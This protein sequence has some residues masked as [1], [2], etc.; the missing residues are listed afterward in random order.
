MD[1]ELGDIVKRHFELN[2]ELMQLMKMTDVQRLGP[3]ASEQ[4]LARIEREFRVRLPHD[5]RDF[6]RRHNGW[7]GFDGELD[8][9]STQQMRDERIRN[10][11]D[12]IAYS[13][14]E[15]GLLPSEK[16]FIIQGSPTAKEI[17]FY[18][19]SDGGGEE[20]Q[21]FSWDGEELDDYTDFTDFLR[22]SLEALEDLI[23]EE[24][25]RL[26]KRDRQR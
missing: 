4:D 7:S 23:E 1:T 19:F 12:T 14:R 16:I 6:L 24:K 22:S 2:R 3:P 8:L 21:L 11:I 5:Y 9:L 17:T 13:L 26:R 15:A 10:Q 18:G 20:P 25:S